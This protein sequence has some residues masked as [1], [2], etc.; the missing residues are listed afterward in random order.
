MGHKFRAGLIKVATGE[1]IN[2]E[3]ERGIFDY[4]GLRYIPPEL[5]NA[6]G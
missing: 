5:R 4:L 1:E 6:D 3:T 2:L